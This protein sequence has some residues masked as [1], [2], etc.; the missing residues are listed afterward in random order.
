MKKIVTILI[1][2]I[3]FSTNAQ[4]KSFTTKALNDVLLT[5]EGTEI[6]FSDIL[7]TYKGKTILIDIWAGWC[8][9]CIKGM[10]KVKKLQKNNK[11]VVF[12]FLS[13]DKTEENWQKAIKTFKIKGEHYY[14]A[15]GW[16]GAFCST[17]D[18]DWIPRYMIVNPEGEI[19]LYKAIKAD[20]P[21]IE[22]VLKGL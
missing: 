4:E 9:D 16:K 22:S 17:I 5:E 6:T 19:V 12:L 20:D 10:P 3:A 2:V 7:E 21:Q 8:S 11:N 18:L 15:S 13:L 1:L 14:L